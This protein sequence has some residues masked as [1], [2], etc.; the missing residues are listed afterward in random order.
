ME[1]LRCILGRLGG[2]I[3][4]RPRSEAVRL[5]Q[6][7]GAALLIETV[8]RCVARIEEKQ[9]LFRA[10]EEDI[11]PIKQVID[12][13]TPEAVGLAPDAHNHI[14]PPSLDPGDVR[15]LH[16]AQDRDFS[17]G[18]FV[19]PPG[20]CIPLHDHPHMCVTSKVLYGSLKVTCYDRVDQSDD[21][22][23]QVIPE[24][25][26]TGLWADG[27]RR[28]WGQGLLRSDSWHDAPY[29]CWLTSTVGNLH[30][31]QAGADGCAVLDVLIPPYDMKCG[32]DC[33]YYQVER[34]GGSGI[35]IN[36]QT[37][38]GQGQGKGQAQQA[39][40]RTK[41]NLIPC[42]LGGR[43]FVAGGEYHGGGHSSEERRGSGNL[44]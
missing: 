33:T 10:T 35:D 1:T 31:L 30:K 32:R 28:R 40:G 16:I 8:Q 43:F 22:G 2:L 3:L 39:M 29:T 36:W 13:I 41:V 14:H 6:T 15:Y 42:N 37:D 24:V 11:L 26:A 4:L 25:G 7:S 20:S 18:I 9:S 34:H 12:K 27:K 38:Q 17:I 5:D 44:T 19:F 23:V 21:D